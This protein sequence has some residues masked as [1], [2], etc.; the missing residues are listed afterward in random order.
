VTN[1]I[2]RRLRR[3][4]G[5]GGIQSLS[6]RELNALLSMAYREVINSADATEAHKAEARAKLEGLE[7]TELTEAEKATVEAVL[8]AL[9]KEQTLQQGVG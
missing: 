5:P 6:D 4:E 2:E 8:A 7:K 3:L 9:L 1:A